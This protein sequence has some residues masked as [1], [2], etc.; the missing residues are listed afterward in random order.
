MY[1]SDFLQLKSLWAC[2]KIQEYSCT[3]WY[4]QPGPCQ[5]NKH[6]HQ[7]FPRDSMRENLQK[8]SPV[9][10]RTVRPLPSL[11][12]IV[13]YAVATTPCLSPA[14]NSFELKEPRH[15]CHQP[16]CSPNQE[17]IFSTNGIVFLW[18]C[19]SK[20]GYIMTPAGYMECPKPSCVS[21]L[22]RHWF[23]NWYLDTTRKKTNIISLSAHNSQSL[24]MP[25][26]LLSCTRT[27]WELGLRNIFSLG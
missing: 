2:T 10:H 15:W 5:S 14:R 16:V 11:R 4:W 17:S 22:L 23:K 7:F 8:F 1:K 27:L 24:P 6:L 25:F 19:F 18:L 9:T 20:C 21:I 12:Y 26:R 13:T 3:P